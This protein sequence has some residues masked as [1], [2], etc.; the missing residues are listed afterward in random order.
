MMTPSPDPTEGERI[1]AGGGEERADEGRVTRRRGARGGRRRERVRR[2]T[3][4]RV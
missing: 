2:N 1:A 3:V 4:S